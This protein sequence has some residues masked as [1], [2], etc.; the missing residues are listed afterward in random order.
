MKR[1]E[2]GPQVE[3]KDFR[4]GVNGFPRAKGLYRRGDNGAIQPDRFYRAWNVQFNGDEVTERGGQ[5]EFCTPST[6]PVMGLYSSN[7]AWED[8]PGLPGA[9]AGDDLIAWFNGG[10]G[11]TF[12]PT[13]GVQVGNCAGSQLWPLDAPNGETY[14]PTGM[15]TASGLEAVTTNSVVWSSCWH[16]GNVFFS[17]SDGA[18]TGSYTSQ[19]IVYCAPI[20]TTGAQTYNANGVFTNITDAGLTYVG[21]NT[22]PGTATT[23]NIGAYLFS[24]AGDLY[25]LYYRYNVASRGLLRKWS[26][27]GTTWST[28]GT[29]PALTARIGAGN[30]YRAFTAV[31]SGRWAAEL[32]GAMYLVIQQLVNAVTDAPSINAISVLK[33]DGTAITEFYNYAIPLAK[34][35]TLVYPNWTTTGAAYCPPQDFMTGQNVP[36]EWSSAASQLGS[37]FVAGANIF[38]PFK[39]AWSVDVGTNTLVYGWH[40]LILNSSGYV[41]DNVTTQT[42]VSVQNWTFPSVPPTL[43]TEYPGVASSYTAFPPYANAAEISG[44][45]YGVGVDHS[46]LGGTGTGVFLYR[47]LDG[48]AWY[49]VV[50]TGDSNTTVP[51]RALTKLTL[52]VR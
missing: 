1:T 21:N 34:R 35:A 27:S 29:F 20:D 3:S 32:E 8:Y 16:S 43:S 30:D 18:L 52:L 33:F 31:G 39:V 28:V 41:G 46:T 17:V 15:A 47:S 12:N 7:A 2:G 51:K 14:S 9:G 36:R 5:S 24:Y 23:V 40:C 25:A 50:S 11:R 37:V 44:V 10:A 19:K 48:Y 22:A 49:K 13:A 4:Y 26:G 42:L 38:I 45:L 6:F